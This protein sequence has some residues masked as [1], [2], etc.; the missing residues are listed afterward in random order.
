[1]LLELKIHYYISFNSVSSKSNTALRMNYQ[2]PLDGYLLLIFQY[3]LILKSP[4][5]L[6]A[7][8][9]KLDSINNIFICLY[10]H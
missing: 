3:H 1:M 2:I 4:S 9:S 6:S 8:S 10:P 5:S 7:R